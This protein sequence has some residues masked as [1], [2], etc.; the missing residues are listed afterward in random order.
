MNTNE[1]TKPFCGDIFFFLLVAFDVGGYTD[2]YR[3]CLFVLKK[4]LGQFC[5]LHDFTGHD[6]RRR[7]WSSSLKGRHQHGDC[8]STFS[9]FFLPSGRL[10]YVFLVSRHCFLTSDVFGSALCAFWIAT[11][12][13]VRDS[14]SFLPPRRMTQ[15]LD[16]S[17][18]QQRWWSLKKKH[19]KS[20][21]TDQPLF[22]A[23]N[24]ECSP[25]SFREFPDLPRFLSHKTQ[26]VLVGDRIWWAARSVEGCPTA[27]SSRTEDGSTHG[28][29]NTFAT[30]KQMCVK[31]EKK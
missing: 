3:V 20:T 24:F 26:V 23:P 7:M 12:D 21:K 15:R 25:C 14:E 17:R 2:C 9:M 10:G 8:N 29:N 31:C 28:M 22:V 19:R 13:L 6:R 16:Y 27:A 18:L 5:R 4:T 11:I 1:P 30:S